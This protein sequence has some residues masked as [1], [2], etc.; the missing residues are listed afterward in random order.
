MDP[1]LEGLQLAESLPLPRRDL[2][3]AAVPGVGSKICWVMTGTRL[4]PELFGC[5]PEAKQNK[6]MLRQRAQGFVRWSGATL[7]LVMSS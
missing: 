4:G 2:K 1:N 6:E 5:P 3:S 7:G